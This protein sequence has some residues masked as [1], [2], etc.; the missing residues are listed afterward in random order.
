MVALSADKV[1]VVVEVD[2]DAL[3]DHLEALRP[4]DDV[5]VG[6]FGHLATILQQGLLLLLFNCCCRSVLLPV[7]ERVV[8]LRHLEPEDGVADE[9]PDGDDGSD[10]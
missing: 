8:S 2:T 5:R 7:V 4:K 6:H 3:V 1:S 10:D 9:E